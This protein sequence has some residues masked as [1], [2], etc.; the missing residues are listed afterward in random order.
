MK[1]HEVPR[2]TRVRVTEPLTPPPGGL[3]IEAKEYDF[4]HIDGM[5]SYCKDDEDNVVH[6]AAWTEVEIV[7]Q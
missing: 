1:L 5:Y 4:Y 6:L 7:E 3:P 2:N